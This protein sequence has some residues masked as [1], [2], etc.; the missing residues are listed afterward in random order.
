[1]YH[2]EHFLQRYDTPKFA[3]LLSMDV[4]EKLSLSSIFLS[5]LIIN[6]RSSAI[7]DKHCWCNSP[8]GFLKCFSLKATEI[9]T[10]IIRTVEINVTYMCYTYNLV[11]KCKKHL[12]LC[13][14]RPEQ[15]WS[16]FNWT[17]SNQQSTSPFS[18]Q[19]SRILITFKLYKIG[20][21]Q[22]LRHISTF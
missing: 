16:I 9:W 19:V 14:Y 22:G 13:I 11:W 15:A 1:M 8:E 7:L 12:F 21:Q 4:L 6:S 10:S 17:V 20:F 5:Q 18:W 2:F 3:P